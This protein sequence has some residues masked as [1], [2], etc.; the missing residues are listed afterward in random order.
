MVTNRQSYETMLNQLMQTSA[1]SADTVS[2]IARIVDPA[3]PEFTPVKPDKRRMV[4]IGLI[5]ALMGGIGIALMLDRFD[6][7]LKSRED[8]EERLGI[9][10]LGELMLLKGKRADGA[11]FV[12]AMEYLDEPTSRFAESV[13]TIRT[14]V[15]LSGLD[16]SQQTLV[17]TSTVS[18]EGKSTVALNLAL[19]LGQ[20]GHVLLI[21]ADLRRPAMARVFGLD[22]STPGLTDLVAGTAKV[23]EC[24][25]TVPGDIHVLCAGSTLPPDPLKILSSERFAQVLANAA[26]SYDTVV[27]DSAP[28]ELVSDARVLAT[29]ASGVVYVIKADATRP[30]GRAPGTECPERHRH[31]AARR[32][33]EPGQSR[34]GAWL[35]QIQIRVFPLRPLQP[36]RL[37]PGHGVS[38]CRGARTGAPGGLARRNPPGL[39]V[40][41]TR[42]RPG[43]PPT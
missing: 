15:A 28:L 11:P 36:L 29:R 24:I 34:R 38:G 2:M 12:P 37:R 17:V 22:S 33:T 9:P 30:P 21:D 35:W 23:T 16:Q 1:R 43:T 20:L 14:G 13:R 7:T 41:D 31:A 26:A 6:N 39:R 10:V 27:I 32:R 8:V 19:A 42:D 3:V 4:M 40:S 18:A 5:L 25:R